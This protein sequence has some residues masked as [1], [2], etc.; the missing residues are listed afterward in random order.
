[1]VNNSANVN[2][3]LPRQ[4]IE[5]KN[6]PT[7]TEGYSS[8]VEDSYKYMTRLNWFIWI[9]N[10]H[11]LHNWIV[12]GNTD[13]NEQIQRNPAQIISHSQRQHTEKSLTLQS[14]EL[15]RTYWRLFNKRAICTTLY[16]IY[17][18]ISIILSIN[19]QSNIFFSRERLLHFC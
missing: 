1:M 18:Y 11:H 5:H 2:K 13:I 19:H 15:D 10:F 14:F 6:I 4:L 17:N 8:T 7:I 12:H 9:L 16:D 3:H